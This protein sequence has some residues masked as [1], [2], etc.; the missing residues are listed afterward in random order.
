[1]EMP[2]PSPRWIAWRSPWQRTNTVCI[3]SPSDSYPN[4]TTATTPSIAATAVVSRALGN[5]PS[6]R[7]SSR[8]LGVAGCGLLESSLISRHH[9]GEHVVEERRQNLGV[10]QDA[11]GDGFERC[12]ERDEAGRHEHREADAE[13]LQRRR[14]SGDERESGLNG[15]R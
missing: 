8:R 5:L 12:G 9:A 10:L 7:A 2:P 14:H 4:T 13:D 15:E 6:L 11:G 3:S 1:A